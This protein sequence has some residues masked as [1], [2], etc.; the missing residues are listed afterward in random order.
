MPDNLSGDSVNGVL[1]D[2][3]GQIGHPAFMYLGQVIEYGPTEK[4]FT[5]PHLKET[6][7]YTTVRF[8]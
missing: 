4:L 7:D 1:G 2:I 3:R 6:E 8:G 5:N